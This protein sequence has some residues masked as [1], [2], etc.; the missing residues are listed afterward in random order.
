MSKGR[1][2]E[3]EGVVEEEGGRN[4]AIHVLEE[5]SGKF[6]GAFLF[7]FSYS[8]F[9]VLI[10]L[11]LLLCFVWMVKLMIPMLLCQ[12]RFN[13]TFKVIFVF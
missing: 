4:P 9:F 3:K 1:F 2:W 12:T 8:V 6:T 7:S 10:L 11:C 13:A 5:L